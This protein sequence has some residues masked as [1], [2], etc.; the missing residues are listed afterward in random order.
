[1]LSFFFCS[2]WL[3]CS[4]AAR[5]PSAAF[6]NLW[7]DSLG[8]ELCWMIAAP[9]ERL[10]GSDL[11]THM[12]SYACKACCQ[13]M[14]KRLYVSMKSTSQAACQLAYHKTYTCTYPCYP[15]PVCS[16]AA[17]LISNQN[18]LAYGNAGSIHLSSVLNTHN[19]F[20]VVG[21]HW[22]IHWAGPSSANALVAGAACTTFGLVSEIRFALVAGQ[23]ACGRGA[24]TRH[25]ERTITVYYSI[26]P[27]SHCSEQLVPSVSKLPSNYNN[28]SNNH[29]VHPGMQCLETPSHT[30]SARAYIVQNGTVYRFSLSL[31]VQCRWNSSVYLLS[32]N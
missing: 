17:P 26:Q 30:T 3:R 29:R 22:T 9:K 2:G 13:N 7:L 8:V 25:H 15:V 16:Y 32:I 14:P 21:R 11:V 4:P 23:A 31:P 20:D 6:H 1:M 18:K 19:K 5:P 10:V 12:N 27:V 24:H 28:P